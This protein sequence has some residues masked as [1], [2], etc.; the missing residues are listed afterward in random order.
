MFVCD[1]RFIFTKV[2]LSLVRRFACENQEKSC[3]PKRKS[4]ATDE[5]DEKWKMTV[6]ASNG[7]Q[8]AEFTA[9]SLLF[10]VTDAA[11]KQSDSC[12]PLWEPKLR[13]IIRRSHQ[14]IRKIHC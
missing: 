13:E 6:E 4:A 11:A 1:V 5:T 8:S 9:Y 10:T 14:A 12:K 2:L 7:S 3:I